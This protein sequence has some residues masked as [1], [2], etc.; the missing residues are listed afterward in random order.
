MG[1]R[2]GSARW[3]S[4]PS[5]GTLVLCQAASKP[6]SGEGAGGGVRGRERGQKSACMVCRRQVQSESGWIAGRC[7]AGVEQERCVVI[8]MFAG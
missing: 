2:K 8:E 4:A 5:A 1:G 7:S 6:V 3:S